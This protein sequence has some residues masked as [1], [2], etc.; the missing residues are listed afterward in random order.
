M[1]FTNRI[2]TAIQVGSCVAIMLLAIGWLVVTPI[3]ILMT[4]QTGDGWLMFPLS[5]VL[6]L[7]TGGGMTLWLIFREIVRAVRTWLE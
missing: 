6:A 4:L 7:A 2:E 1:D 5:L 3:A